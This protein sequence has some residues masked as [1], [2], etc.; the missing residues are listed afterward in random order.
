MP[1]DETTAEETPEIA[2]PAVLTPDEVN[3][4]PPPPVPTR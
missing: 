4:P 1:T 3:P 2:E